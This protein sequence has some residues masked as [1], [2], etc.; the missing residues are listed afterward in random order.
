MIDEMTDEQFI[1]ALESVNDD[2]LYVAYALDP[3]LYQR[4]EHERS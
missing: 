3:L 1:A 2:D 4:K